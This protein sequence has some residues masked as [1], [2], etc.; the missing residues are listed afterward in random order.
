MVKLEIDFRKYRTHVELVEDLSPA[1]LAD[2]DTEVYVD[3]VLKTENSLLYSDFLV[4]V[5]SS[6]K[7]LRSAGIKVSGMVH[8]DGN[9]DNVNYASRV[10]FFQQLG[11]E[12]SEKFERKSG[13]G[14]FTEILSF[15][16]VSIYELQEK[17]NFILYQNADISKEILQLL[18]YCLNEIMDNVLVHSKLDHGWVSCQYFNHAKEI[19]LIICDTGN[20]IHRSLTTNP[21]TKYPDISEDDA[22]RLCIQRGVTNGEGLGFGLFATSEF[23]KK[24]QG[25]LL[26]YSGDHFLTVD[27]KTVDL[28]KGGHW[29]GTFVFL[30]IN[31][32]IPVDYHEI[33]PDNHSLPD[34]YQE[35]I[36]K[37]LDFSNDL[38]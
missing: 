30:R 6:I 24:N 8:I 28:R 23:I 33:M 4:L 21:K 37:K 34:D 15:D 13:T 38:W 16:A 27:S 31:T 9:S 12:F 1:F 29:K 20:G 36:E 14:K 19:R 22:L 18:Y 25:D 3:I 10:N 11:L 2:T 17:L 7:Y 5:I 26:I 32:E 35:F